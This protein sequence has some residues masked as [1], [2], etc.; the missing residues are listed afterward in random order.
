MRPRRRGDTRWP[1]GYAALSSRPSPSSSW[2]TRCGYSCGARGGSRVVSRARDT[3]TGGDRSRSW[4]CWSAYRARP[5]PSPSCLTRG[6]RASARVDV[7]F[8]LEVLPCC[9]QLYMTRVASLTSVLEE[10]RA[11]RGE[12][13]ELVEVH[14]PVPVPVHHLDELRDFVQRQRFAERFEE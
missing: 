6:D 1:P 14:H 13:E 9:S 4:S 5:S 2:C 7:F 8:H 3:T 10:P 11:P 12:V